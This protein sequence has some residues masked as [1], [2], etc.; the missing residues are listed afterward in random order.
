MRRLFLFGAITTLLVTMV[1][2][3]WAATNLNSSR[4]NNYRV[5]Y[6]TTAV[7]PAQMV[8]VLKAL[9]KIGP[10]V[11]EAEV[12]RV[13]QQQGVNLAPIKKISILPPDKTR[14]EP[15]IMLLKNQ[16]DEVQ[17]RHIAVSDSGVGGPKSPPITIKK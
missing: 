13:L 10:G 4:S 8:G 6:D 14:K 17:A 15:L 3:S 1:S 5:T 16:A 2:I 7:T 11:N 9:D 12:R